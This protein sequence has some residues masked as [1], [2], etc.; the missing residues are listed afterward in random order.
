[1]NVLGSGQQGQ[2]Q[3]YSV[4]LNDVSVG[5]AAPKNLSFEVFTDFSSDVVEPEN[6]VLVRMV[7][8]SRYVQ[9]Y[10][11]QMTEFANCSDIAFQPGQIRLHYGVEI[12]DNDCILD[13]M[14]PEDRE[15]WRAVHAALPQLVLD[16]APT[17]PD[18]ARLSMMLEHKLEEIR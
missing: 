3:G 4:L 9:N 8:A 14:V 17:D 1:V 5:D 6:L 11:D 10:A 2:W 12:L 18:A 15:L 7:I 13:R 16:L